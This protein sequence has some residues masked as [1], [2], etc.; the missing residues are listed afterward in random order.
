MAGKKENISKRGSITQGVV[1]SDRNKKTV[2][3]QRDLVIYVPKF[4][5]YA[6]KISR[7]TAHNPEEISAKVGDVVQ[8]AECRKISKTKA[9]VVTKIIQKGE[10]HLKMGQVKA[11]D[12]LQRKT[13]EEKKAEP[14]KENKPE[15]Q[16]TDGE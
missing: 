8:I 12:E 10:G 5:R 15:V 7:I 9:W 11:T 1:V 3:V 16:A 6:R 14:V 4:K 13:R 2:V